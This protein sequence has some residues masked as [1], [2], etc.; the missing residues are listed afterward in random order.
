MEQRVQARPDILRQRKELVEHVFGT[1]KRHMQ[2]GYFL[3]KTLPK[4]RAEFSL[5]VLTYNLKRVIAILG[6]G[7]LLAALHDHAILE[8]EVFHQTGLD[9]LVKPIWR[10][11]RWFCQKT[12]LGYKF[13]AHP[14]R[15]FTHSVALTIHSAPRHAGHA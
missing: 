2:H 6:V 7:K 15:V 5:T 4:V 3:L 8:K 1:M 13:R 14:C 9:V 11:H 12:K 10:V